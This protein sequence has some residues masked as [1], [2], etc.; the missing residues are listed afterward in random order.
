MALSSLVSTT[1]ILNRIPSGLIVNADDTVVGE[2]RDD[3]AALIERNTGITYISGSDGED[4]AIAACTSLATAMVLSMEIGEPLSTAT[5][6]PDAELK[7]D[8]STTEKAVANAIKFNW[9]SFQNNLAVLT[10]T[11]SIPT[12]SVNLLENC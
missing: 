1:R 6:T 5:F 7:I 12:S 10:E 9:Q 11:I 2:M 3:A 8:L 4:V